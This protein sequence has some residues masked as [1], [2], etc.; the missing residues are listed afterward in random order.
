MRGGGAVGIAEK[1]LQGSGQR[2]E[3]LHIE[4]AEGS[5]GRCCYLFLIK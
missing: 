2:S 3:P 5:R 4:V 1:F